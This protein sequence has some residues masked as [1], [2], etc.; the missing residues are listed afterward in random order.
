MGGSD[1]RK[2]EGMTLYGSTKYGLRYLTDALVQETKG[3]P[4]VVGAFQPGM[5]VTDLLT[6]QYEERPEDWERAKRVFN[7]LADR[8]ET[9]APWLAEKAL[10]NKKKGVRIKWLGTAKLMGRFVM[11]RFVKRDLF[12]EK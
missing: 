1:G 11:S 10:A 9:V 6:Q 4:V 2:L 5:V 3:T 8:V 12:G 7:I